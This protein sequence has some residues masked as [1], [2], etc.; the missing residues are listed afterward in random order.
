[1]AVNKPD[2]FRTARIAEG[3]FQVVSA[4]N[5]WLPTPTP[6]ELDRGID[7]RV[8]I[9]GPE[10]KRP[11]LEFYVQLKG[12]NQ[13]FDTNHVLDVR[14]EKRALEYWSAKLLPVLVVLVHNPTKTLYGK[15]FDGAIPDSAE[16][17][18]FKFSNAETLSKS[19]IERDVNAYFESMRA[20]IRRPESIS[21]YGQLVSS[22]LLL[23]RF[24]WETEANLF[25][26]RWRDFP[27]AVKAEHFEQL[28]FWYTFFVSTVRDFRAPR[29]KGLASE[30]GLRIEEQFK[31]IER[32][33]SAFREEVALGDDHGLAWGF[34]AVDID[35]FVS[36]I[37]T[38]VSVLLETASM[39]VDAMSEALG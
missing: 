3:L 37:P 39:V 18:S 15:W 13:A 17:K 24:Y 28:Q 36:R 29:P 8:E 16:S 4:E 34:D 5:G 21:G 31:L 27:S 32:D 10:G 19:L 2:S 14:I 35:E 25:G 11:T 6:L 9:P 7:Y 26:P 30:I 1:M 23:V 20:A 33:A 22:V 12:T 38:V